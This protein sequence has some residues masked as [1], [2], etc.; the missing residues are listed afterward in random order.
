[1]ASPDHPKIALGDLVAVGAL[2]GIGFTVSLLLANL[3]F[4]AEPIVRDKAVLGVLS[5]SV[6]SVI[7][8]AALLT[9]R[10]R[11]HRRAGTAVQEEA[12]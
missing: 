5:G 8:A 6:I 2:G 12:A 10:V 7:V 11:H 4:A 3:A 1:M 9:Q